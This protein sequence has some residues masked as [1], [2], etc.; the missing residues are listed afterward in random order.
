VLKVFARIQGSAELPVLSGTWEKA[1]AREEDG[2]AVS[3]WV[4]GLDVR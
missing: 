1:L 3:V 4:E 2:F